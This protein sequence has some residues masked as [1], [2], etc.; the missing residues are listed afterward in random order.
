[1]AYKPRGSHCR[2]DQ[3][4]LL[5]PRTSK[6]GSARVT[7]Y[8]SRFLF[9]SLSSPL[10]PAVVVEKGREGVSC[11]KMHIDLYLMTDRVVSP[12]A[13]CICGLISSPRRGKQ[14]DAACTLFPD[15]RERGKSR[16]RPVVFTRDLLFIRRENRGEHGNIL[17]VCLN[18][19]L[20]RHNS[21]GTHYSV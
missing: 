13:G 9:F 2:S 20:F 12:A 5:V 15:T 6:I 8:S 17:Q 19:L 21:Y 10:P 3:S 18:S 1:M 16:L 11:F 7:D 4:P 14:L